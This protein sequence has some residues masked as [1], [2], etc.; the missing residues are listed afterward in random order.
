MWQGVCVLCVHCSQFSSSFHT[1][2]FYVWRACYCLHMSIFFGLRSNVHIAHNAFFAHFFIYALRTQLSDFSQLR[3][4][5]CKMIY[6]ESVFM[7]I[8]RITW[9]FFFLVDFFCLLQW[10][11]T[12]NFETDENE[13]TLSCPLFLILILQ[14][15]LNFCDSMKLISKKRQQFFFLFFRFTLTQW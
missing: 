10:N 13:W 8:Y 7:G 12:W 9:L 14:R 5:Q 1:M 11:F 4:L 3:H 2:C 6:K 15:N